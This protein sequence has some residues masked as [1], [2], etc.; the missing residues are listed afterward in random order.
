MDADGRYNEM[1]PKVFTMQ[2]GIMGQ[3]PDAYHVMGSDQKGLDD[4]LLALSRKQIEFKD[5]D[6]TP[7]VSKVDL[8]PACSSYPTKL[9]TK[10]DGTRANRTNGDAYGN[11]ITAKNLLNVKPHESDP[12]SFLT[13]T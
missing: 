12:R 8:I 2:S 11:W 4:A 5:M 13:W 10:L 9:H 1:W 7:L 3:S 6:L